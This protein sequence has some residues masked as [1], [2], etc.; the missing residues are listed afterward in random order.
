M[1]LA[2]LGAQVRPYRDYLTPALHRRFNKA[3]RYTLLLCYV[4]ACWM[5]E[6]NN[7]LWLWFPLGLT[8]IRTLL[9]F[10]CALTI[11]VLRVAQWHVGRRHTQTRA[12]TFRKYFFRLSTILTLVA[13]TFSAAMYVETYI[14]S[15]TAKDR[16]AFI[17]S[18][19]MHERFRLNERPLYL[20]YLFY[21]LAMAQSGVHLSR[22]YD[23]I[24]VP[25]TMPKKDREDAAAAAPTPKQ[26]PEPR[27]VL[28]RQFTSMATKSTS[29]A[30]AVTAAGFAFYFVV[31]RNLIWGYYYAFC[32]Y[33]WSL[34][35]T[36]APTGL[37]PFLP[38]CFMFLAEG[39]LLVLLWEF[40][41]KAFDVYIAQEPLKNHL[42]ITND[43]KDPNGTLLNGL[44]SKKDAVKA[45]A[46][47]ELA[48]ITDAFPD[49]R[50][51]IYGE[52][53]RKKAPTFQQ[54][55]DIC[56][57]E[58]KH[59]ILR[60][61]AGL[62][63]AYNPVA[64]ADKP[65]PAAP[66]KLVPQI[67]QP[68]KE[69]GQIAAPPPKPNTKWGHVEA[70][71]SGIAKSQSAPGNAKQAYSREVINRGMQKAQEGARDAEG[72]L[73]TYYNRLVSSP[74]GALFRQPLQRTVNIVVL[75][76]PYSRVSLICNAVT[77]LTNLS[78]FSLSQDELGRFHHGI[79]EI[80]RV[81]TTAIQKMDEY[82]AAVPIHWS[83]KE[84]LSKP[85]AE[86]RKVREVDE[87]RECLREGLE[88]ILGS[89]NE[90][91]GG[92]GLSKLE[93]LDAKKV[94]GVKRAPEMIQAGAAR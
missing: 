37:A 28:M 74:L 81:F 27:Q 56:L 21:S 23:K 51:T 15:R 79:P 62:D 6:W 19:R 5:G 7:M 49:R 53:E 14:W 65:Q 9:I 44:K 17:E 68:L 87:V 29:L 66:V 48:L 90:Y 38:L 2:S 89:F 40:V 43:S 50:R 25:A 93:I 69:D 24:D 18:G 13:Y 80:V 45:I 70:A 57:G 59:L 88:R 12:E 85:E 16:L 64:V 3:S 75:G 71:V 82:M 63:P 67:S 1:A 72:T 76:A 33:L 22:D 10:L 91:L 52:I 83:D 36:S 94:V 86:R 61:N 41:N 35:K 73:K 4:I 11:Y 26:A 55:T 47:W 54:V 77:A 60:L 42:P 30:A 8:G 32:R 31:T 39:T 34:S 84:T 92:V 20:R 58:L 46:F 78:V